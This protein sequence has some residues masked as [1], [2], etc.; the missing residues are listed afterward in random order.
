MQALCARACLD[1][2]EHLESLRFYDEEGA[3]KGRK[4]P[5]VSD[6]AVRLHRMEE[7]ATQSM[8]TNDW[9]T[10]EESTG[11]GGSASAPWWKGVPD[12]YGNIDGQCGGAADT[13]VS[14]A[15][16]STEAFGE[17]NN[18]RATGYLMAV[19]CWRLVKSYDLLEFC[20][21]RIY[22]GLVQNDRKWDGSVRSDS[23]GCLQ[24]MSFHYL[25]R[26]FHVWVTGG[27]KLQLQYCVDERLGTRDRPR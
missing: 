27:Y 14:C 25:K 10:E 1:F 2:D 22:S 18:P 12:I 9:D 24:E 11:V 19:W 3:S 15:T 8:F 6:T 20:R 13:A 4:N 21:E 17:H 16:S 5:L 7:T 23:L 26:S